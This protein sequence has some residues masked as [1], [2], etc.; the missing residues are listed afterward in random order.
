MYEVFKRHGYVPYPL[1]HTLKQ[2]SRDWRYL[3]E[4]LTR[5]LPRAPA[6]RPGPGKAF[7]ER[8]TVDLRL[9]VGRQRSDSQGNVVSEGEADIGFETAL[10]AVEAWERGEDFTPEQPSGS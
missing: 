10:R 6:S 2:W 8:C 1:R 5:L 4:W 3:A 7:A 9:R